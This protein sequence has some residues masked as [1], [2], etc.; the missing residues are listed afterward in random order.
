M[1]ELA[2]FDNGIAILDDG[3]TYRLVGKK[4]QQCDN[5]P[6]NRFEPIPDGGDS[7]DTPDE[8]FLRRTEHFNVPKSPS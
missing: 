8:P 5:L 1:G 4:W 7:K 2:A 3:R 6:V